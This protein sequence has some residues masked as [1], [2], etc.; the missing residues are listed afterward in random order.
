MRVG[1]FQLSRI[2]FVGLLHTCITKMSVEETQWIGYFSQLW[3]Y[4]YYRVL[5]LA[6][7]GR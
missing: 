1:L 5:F 3:F 4:L 7:E 2:L 6:V